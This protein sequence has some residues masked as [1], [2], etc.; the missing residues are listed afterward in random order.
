LKIPIVTATDLVAFLDAN[1]DP[2]KNPVILH[3]PE[4]EHLSA[5]DLEVLVTDF[6][7]KKKAL[8]ATQ[9]GAKDQENQIDAF[10]AHRLPSFI[11]RLNAA[12]VLDPGFW[13]YLSW[14][15][16]DVISWRHEGGKYV[17]FGANFANLQ[18]SFLGRSYLR[19]KIGKT[20]ARIDVAGSDLWRSHIIRVKA[21]NSTAISGALLDLVASK[22]L[23]AKDVRPLA[24]LINAYRS[25]VLFELLTEEGAKA[26]VELIW[27]EYEKS[28]PNDSSE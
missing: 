3:G 23:P 27:E 9:V 21:G 25:N 26:A 8:V 4:D 6:L 16:F 13:A 10:A 12:T 20:Q 5:V 19:G 2:E 1:G 11:D 7:E 14:R 22:K 17:N 24:K 28:Q 15:L 18:E